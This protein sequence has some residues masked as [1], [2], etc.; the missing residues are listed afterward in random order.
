MKSAYVVD[1]TEETIDE[2]QWKLDLRTS[3]A[4]LNCVE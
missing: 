1:S 4:K 3:A 2:S